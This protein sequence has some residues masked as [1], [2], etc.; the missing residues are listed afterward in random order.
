VKDLWER[1]GGAAYH[2]AANTPPKVALAQAME[3]TGADWQLLARNGWA[4]PL[5]QL[6]HNHK[7]RDI[8]IQHSGQVWVRNAKGQKSREAVHMSEDWLRFL[9][10]FWHEATNPNGRSWTEQGNPLNPQTVT[11]KTLLFANGSGGLR[12]VYAPATFSSWGSSLYIRRLPA[13]PIPLSE[14]V[15]NGTL[16]QA[17]ADLLVAFLQTGTP[18]VISGQS[19]A[20]KTTLLAALVHELQAMADP[21]NLLIVERTHEIPTTGPAFRWEQDAEGVVS[22]DHLAEKATQMGLEWLVLGE[23]TG[24]EAYFVAKAFSQGVPAMT[25]LHANSASAAIKKLAMLS[26][27]YVQDP[28][29]LPVIMT[30]LANQGLVSVHLALKERE[31]HGLLGMVTGIVETIGMSGT[32]EPVVNPLWEW[33]EANEGRAPGLYWNPGSVSQLAEATR[34]RFVATGATFPMPATARKKTGL[35]PR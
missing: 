11:R 23:C 4:G 20:G 16:P 5:H 13:R 1:L 24:P 22:L 7:V 10:Q 21:L 12:Y 2:V 26:L 3:K 14:M 27:E 9:P 29:L 28:R 30:D 25:T 33:R 35:W 19:G 8:I 32:S 15:R 31:P 18:M 34:H 17:A 6:V